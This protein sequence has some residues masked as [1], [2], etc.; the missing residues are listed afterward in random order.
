MDSKGQ[1]QRNN[2]P[3][4]NPGKYLR[5]TIAAPVLDASIQEVNFALTNL[6]SAA[7]LP[8]FYLQNR[9]IEN[10]EICL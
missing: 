9:K 10:Q 8:Y 6:T 7:T 5:R 2:I 3:P 4:E 1:H